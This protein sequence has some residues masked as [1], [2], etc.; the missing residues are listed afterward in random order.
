M[1]PLWG[2]ETESVLVGVNVQRTR[3]TDARMARQTRKFPHPD[4]GWK[5]FCNEIEKVLWMQ[6]IA[7]LLEALPG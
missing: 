6:P 3:N 7:L 5:N 2:N 4:Q 1:L